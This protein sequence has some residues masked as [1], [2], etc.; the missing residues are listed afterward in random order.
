MILV[1][2]TN[3]QVKDIAIY[4]WDHCPHCRKALALLEAKGLQYQQIKLDGDEDAREKMA[5]KTKGQRKSVPQIF[6]GCD[7][8]HA[9][10]ASGELDRLVYGS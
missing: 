9:L 6:I 1:Q 8:L 5:L 2:G 10:D 7:D 4:T 3:K